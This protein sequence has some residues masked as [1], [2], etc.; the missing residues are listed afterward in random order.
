MKKLTLIL[1]AT[2]FAA[3]PATAGDVGGEVST[4]CSITGVGGAVSF[5]DMDSYGQSAAGV[6][7]PGI[8]VFC[9]EPAT[10]NFQSDNG[11]LLNTSVPD[12]PISQN[13]LESSTIAGFNA[14][15]D[16]KFEFD[17]IVNNVNSFPVGWDTSAMNA[18]TTA[19][20]PVDPL[21]VTGASLAY[22]TMPTS[23]PALAGTYEDVL[24]VTI[25]STGF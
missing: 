6:T 2:A 23:L 9:N 1:A 5:A 11:Y 7:V 17:T 22:N 12:A 10:I 24:T 25:T 20:I 18:G 21:N 4:S 13:N 8:N 15:I 14:A 3:I 19:G 16:Y